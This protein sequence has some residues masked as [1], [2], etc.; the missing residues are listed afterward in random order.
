V[1]SSTLLLLVPIVGSAQSDKTPPPGMVFVPGGRTTIGTRVKDVMAMGEED[2]GSFTRTAKETPQH[3]MRVDDFF[4]G[5][6]EVTNEQYLEYV[7]ATGARPPDSWGIEAIDAASIAFVAEQEL[8]RKQAKEA[9]LDAGER[10]KF[11]QVQWWR[12][13]WQNVEWQIPKGRETLPVSYVDYQEA[14]AYARW[15]GV[16][17]MTEFEYQRAGRGRGDA[18]FPWGDAWDPGKCANQTQ[19]SNLPRSVGSFPAGATDTGIFDLVGNVWE[20][21]SSPFNPFPDF[22]VLEL[23]LKQGKEEVV[24]HGVVGWDAN[25]RVV[26]GGS[27]QHGEQAARLTTRRGTDRDQSAEALG[28]RIAASVSPGLDIADVVLRDDVPVSSRPEGV[29]YDPALAVA[30][31]LWRQVPGTAKTAAQ[32][33]DAAGKVPIPGYAVITGYDYIMYIPTTELDVAA[34]TQLKRMSLDEHLVHM[35][36]ISTTKAVLEPQLSPGTYMVAYRG[37]GK[38]R[39]HES[40]AG[41]QAATST[42]KDAVQEP[43]GSD[44]KAPDKLRAPVVYPSDFDPRVANLIFMDTG[45]GMIGHM[46]APEMKYAR[47]EPPRVVIASGKRSTQASDASGMP[48]LDEKGN[49]VMVE[50]TVAVVTLHVNTLV[51]VSNKGFLYDL[52]LKFAEKDVDKEW[53]R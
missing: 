7:K 25:Q 21:T 19:G 48:Q 14:S 31:D 53:R 3:E 16:R 26:V 45:Q 23:K 1:L 35:G 51:R 29:V 39:P 32:D 17:P 5:V 6:T 28:F 9:G 2:R 27:F 8:A 34:L 49:P 20:W 10:R 22:K 4:L 18:V 36:V 37:E 15:A 13:N 43:T 38:L 47:P 41:A 33:K 46:P 42:D 11:D 30:T 40:V 12:D 24:I 44:E 52:E 50:E